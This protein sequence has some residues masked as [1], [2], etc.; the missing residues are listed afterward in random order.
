MTK[1]KPEQGE[2]IEVCNGGDRAAREFLC[3]DKGRFV[4]RSAA[5][6]NS[7]HAYPE[8]YQVKKTHTITLE[9]GTTVEL[10]EESY[11]A[12]KEGVN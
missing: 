4:C 3:M 1:F 6:D 2:M 9:D 10:S 11:Q 7:F 8:G 5:N 12:L